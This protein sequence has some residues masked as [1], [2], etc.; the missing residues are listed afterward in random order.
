MKD[1]YADWQARHIESLLTATSENEFF[2]ALSIAARELGFDYCAY[3]MRLPWPISNP[4]L[5]MVNN[6]PTAWQQRYAAQGFLAVDPT[7]QHGMK[8][9]LPLVWTEKVFEGCRGFWEEARAHGLNVGIAQSSYNAMGV[10]GLLTLARSNEAL[11]EAEIRENSLKVSWLV[12]YAHE[13]MTRLVSAGQVAE[14]PPSLTAREVEV[15]RWTADG[16][17]SGEVGQ[18]MNISERTV[19]FHI[20]NSLVKLGAVNKTALVIKAAMLR[21]L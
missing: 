4:K 1:N 11:S 8:S 7:V 6:Y 21:L 18:I 16:K 14:P 3:G 12:Q 10:G 13:G 5:I 19:N 20:N 2:A 15:L 9:V 17:T